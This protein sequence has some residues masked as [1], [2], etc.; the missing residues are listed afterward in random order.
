MNTTYKTCLGGL[1]TPVVEKKAKKKPAKITLK[2]PG[3][4]APSIEKSLILGAQE[5]SNVSLGLSS[6]ANFFISY[7]LF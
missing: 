5:V 2:T 4:T 3:T 7:Q 1:E 6:L